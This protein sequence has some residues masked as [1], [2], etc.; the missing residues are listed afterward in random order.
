MK[1]K[2]SEDIGEE[3]ISRLKELIAILEQKVKE[4]KNGKKFSIA[5]KG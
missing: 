4:E 2:I 1:E 3:I 5:H